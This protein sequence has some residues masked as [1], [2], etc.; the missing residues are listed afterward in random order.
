MTLLLC[1]LALAL[2]GCELTVTRPCL[3]EGLVP[4]DQFAV[5][6][7][8]AQAVAVARGSAAY[9]GDPRAYGAWQGGRAPDHAD[10][11]VTVDARAPADAPV[12]ERLATAVIQSPTADAGTRRPVFGGRPAS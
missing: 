12:P 3:S 5:R 7:E 8:Q 11:V 9:Q 1:L 6:K 2:A 4:P 10:V